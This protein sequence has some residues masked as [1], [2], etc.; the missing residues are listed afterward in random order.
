MKASGLELSEEA[1]L[2]LSTIEP[3]HV[4]DFGTHKNS[5]SEMGYFKRDKK[6][7]RMIE[8]ADKQGSEE[9]SRHS[10]YLLACYWLR[11]SGI[12][13]TSFLTHT[14][15]GHG[16][17][18]CHLSA[19]AQVLQGGVCHPTLPDVI[20]ALGNIC[21]GLSA[22]CRQ[23]GACSLL[24]WALLARPSRKG[25]R[26]HYLGFDTWAGVSRELA[27]EVQI[28]AVGN[29]SN[30]ICAA[31]KRGFTSNESYFGQKGA[32]QDWK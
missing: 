12:W 18:T 6:E 9:T 25:S 22:R 26:G 27:D 7:K 29:P 4:E 3:E 16:H 24:A 32:V 14:Q 13:H 19:R 8:K 2:A 17:M 11:A 5:L 1:H 10:F 28:G 30:Y 31:V 21:A 23:E 15:K 20:A